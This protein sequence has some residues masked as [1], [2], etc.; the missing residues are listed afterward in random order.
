MFQT[1]HWN[2]ITLKTVHTFSQHRTTLSFI[3]QQVVPTK[4]SDWSTRILDCAQISMTARLTH[5]SKYYSAKSPATLYSS[6]WQHCNCQSCFSICP[7]R[8]ATG[9]GWERARSL[10][11]NGHATRECPVNWSGWWG[12]KCTSDSRDEE[13]ATSAGRLNH[14]L[15]TTTLLA[16]DNYWPEG[17]QRI[18]REA[19]EVCDIFV[20]DFW[21]EGI[22]RLS[23]FAAWSQINAWSVKWLKQI[24][25]RLLFIFPFSVRDTIV[26]AVKTF[27]KKYKRNQIYI[28]VITWAIKIS[29]FCLSV[30]YWFSSGNSKTTIKH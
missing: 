4:Q 14:F 27:Y 25:A 15:T 2:V 9:P 12:N 11:A 26:T 8:T 24:N 1:Q 5:Y 18:H 17:C 19:G 28:F 29:I 22:K 10:S 30:Q 6:P 13:F 16:E 20:P 21:E 3:I 23:Q 7:R